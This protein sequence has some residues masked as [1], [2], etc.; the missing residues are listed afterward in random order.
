MLKKL[1]LHLNKL[2]D[3][4]A[5]ALAEGLVGGWE[6][7]GEEGEWITGDW[8]R[9]GNQTSKIEGPNEQ[10]F[11]ADIYAMVGGI[12]AAIAAAASD[13]ETH[14]PHVPFL[15]ELYLGCNKISDVGADAIACALRT[16]DLSRLRDL[17]LAGNVIGTKGAEELALRLGSGKYSRWEERGRKGRWIADNTWHL[18]METIDLSGNRIGQT[19]LVKLCDMIRE[20]KD[21]MG[22]EERVDPR[23]EAAWCALDLKAV[24]LDDNPG[25]WTGGAIRAMQLLKWKRGIICMHSA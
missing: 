20:G 17:D 1:D 11:I 21:W 8:E 13:R 7:G 18:P 22:E 12:D 24:Y 3:R 6:G 25:L 19:G 2:E 9:R 14:T 4:G 15:E 23:L 16:K 10:A 5:K